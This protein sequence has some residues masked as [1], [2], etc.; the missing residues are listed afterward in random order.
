MARN[1]KT[2]SS[3]RSSRSP[4]RIVSP[5][6]CLNQLNVL[7]ET[8]EV[9]LQDFFKQGKSYQLA[10]LRTVESY[11]GKSHTHVAVIFDRLVR[12]GLVSFRTLA[13]YVGQQLVQRSGDLEA[14]SLYTKVLKTCLRYVRQ[15]RKGLENEPDKSLFPSADKLKAELADG[16]LI[17]V[18]VR[19]LLIIDPR[20]S[21]GTLATAGR[22][23]GA[24]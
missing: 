3:R 21:V 18:E 6:D 13:E 17:A 15:L 14:N 5:S 19:E 8:F 2:C 4:S 16:V 10:C 20:H 1:C 11:W 12:R 24:G 22:P 7:L 23:R 9:V